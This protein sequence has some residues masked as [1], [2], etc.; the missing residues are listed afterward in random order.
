M[1]KKYRILAI[2]PGSTSTKIAVYDDENEVFIKTIRHSAEKIGEYQTIHEQYGF[3]K[4]LILNSLEV[5]GIALG[6]LDAVVAGRQYE[7]GGG[8]TYRVNPAMLEDLR[9]GVLGQHA[10][11]LEVLLPN[12]LRNHWACPPLWWTRLLW[13]SLTTWQGFRECRK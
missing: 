1:D 9:A 8:G 10:S 12:P 6:S 3:R 2:N 7:T 5:N 13:M 11:N 4:E